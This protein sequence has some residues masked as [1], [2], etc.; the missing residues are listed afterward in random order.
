[1]QLLLFFQWI[2]CLAQVCA[3]HQFQDGQWPVQGNATAP[4]RKVFFCIVHQFRLRLMVLVLA[5]QA[6]MQK[7]VEKIVSMMK[8]EGLF[9]WQGGPIIMAQVCILSLL[10]QGL[11]VLAPFLSRIEDRHL[12]GCAGGE[13]VRANGVCRWRWRQAIRKLGRQDG[14]CD[15]HRR[16]VGHVQAR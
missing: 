3:R 15:Q 2:P 1:L 6:A 8:S 13:R 4:G 12:A 5:M 10:L 16:A 7:F 9:E 14:R 11:G